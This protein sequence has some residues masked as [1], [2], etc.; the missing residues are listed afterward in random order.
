MLN[1][2]V[3]LTVVMSQCLH[4]PLLPTSNT[5]MQLFSLFLLDHGEIPTLCSVSRDRHFKLQTHRLIV[6]IPPLWQPYPV[7][8][9]TATWHVLHYNKIYMV[10][11]SEMYIMS[12]SVLFSAKT[13]THLPSTSSWVSLPKPQVPASYSFLL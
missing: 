4:V 2:I 1:I 9:H 10:K 13:R 6:M 8:L 7:L 12:T 3:N 5:P 11:I